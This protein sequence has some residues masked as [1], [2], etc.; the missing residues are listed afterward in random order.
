MANVMNPPVLESKTV[1]Q[2][3]DELNCSPDTIRR[4]ANEFSP[5]L[6]AGASPERGA[7]RMFVERDITMLKTAREQM[8]SGKN[9]DQ[10][11]ADLSLMDMDAG[12]AVPIDTVTQPEVHPNPEFDGVATAMLT[13]VDAVASTQSRLATIPEINERLGVITEALQSQHAMQQQL[14]T[15]AQDINDLNRKN[16]QLAD[17]VQ[18]TR[19]QWVMNVVWALVGTVVTFISLLVIMFIFPQI[20][21]A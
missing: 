18:S 12:A 17:D 16:A 3:A 15:M 5:F 9:F 13:L 2:V 21:G 11:R 20:G 19:R 4:Y 7:T 14:D 1:K 8:S 10:V 6:S